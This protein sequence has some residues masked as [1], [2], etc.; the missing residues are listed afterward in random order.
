MGQNSSANW[1][2]IKLLCEQ[3]IICCEKNEERNKARLS[4]ELLKKRVLKMDTKLALKIY[5]DQECCKLIPS[6]KSF[7]DMLVFHVFVIIK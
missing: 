2:G 7:F 5:F 6:S 3:Y 1:C 4:L